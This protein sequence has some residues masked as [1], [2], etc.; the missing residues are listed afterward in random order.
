MVDVL[1]SFEF[2]ITN[3]E[4]RILLFYFL[5]LTLRQA[6]GKLLTF[7]LILNPEP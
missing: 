1:I 5:L 2:Q 3:Y 7:N 4:L 6:Q